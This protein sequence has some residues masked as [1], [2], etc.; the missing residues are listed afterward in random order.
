MEALEADLKV[1]GSSAA[2]QEDMTL[3]YLKDVMAKSSADV[4]AGE[5]S[6]II[7]TYPLVMGFMGALLRFLGINPGACCNTVDLSRAREA[8]KL[9]DALLFIQ[10]VLMCK[11]EI[12]NHADDLVVARMRLKDIMAIWNP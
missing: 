3:P 7:D 8:T 6:V 10:S 2:E 11:G 4:D 1:A 9:P 5:H 12:E